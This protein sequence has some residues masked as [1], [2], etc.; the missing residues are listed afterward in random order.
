MAMI[1]PPTN[2][3]PGEEDERWSMDRRSR[4]SGTGTVDLSV[5]EGRH[6]VQAKIDRR[7]AVEIDVAADETVALRV[8][9][10]SRPRSS[11]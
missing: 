2:T 5:G 10:G 8:A 7:S 1:R 11:T 9:P 3:G 4:R 6:A